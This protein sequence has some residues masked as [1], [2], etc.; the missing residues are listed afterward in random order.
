SVEEPQG[1]LQQLEDC[2]VEAQR[3]G[4]TVI[5]TYPDDDV[6]GTKARGEKT[7]WARMLADFDAG[8]FEAVLA[9]DVDRLTRSLTDVLELRPPKRDVRVLTVRGGIDTHEDDTTLKL[10]VVLAER[11]VRLKTIRS[12]RYAK[13]RRA[14]GHPPAGRAACASAWARAAARDES[15]TRVRLDQDEAAIVKRIF[16]EFP[17]P[18]PPVQITRDLDRQGLRTRGGF[19]WHTPTRRRIL[20]IPP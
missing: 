8:K 16:R 9:N 14:K 17:A 4:W 10:L 13:E 18:A 7:Q 15:G 20:S 5:D 19:R 3:R 6:S 11:E 2:R 1:I 12:A